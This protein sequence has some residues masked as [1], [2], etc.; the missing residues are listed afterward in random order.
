MKNTMRIMTNKM[1]GILLILGLIVLVLIIGFKDITIVEAFFLIVYFAGI[2]VLEMHLEKKMQEMEQKLTLSDT[3]VQCI[4]TL[5]DKENTDEALDNL[6]KIVGDYF[7]CERAYIFE[8]NPEKK[9]L[10]NTYEYTRMGIMREMGNRQ[11]IPLKRADSWMDAF[12]KHEI[13]VLDN[14]EKENGNKDFGKYEIFIDQH[15]NALIAAPLI[16]DKEIIGFLG[17]ENPTR[18]MKNAS[19]VSSTVYF[20]M[21]NLKKR[22]MQDMLVRLSFEDALTKMY[23]RNKFNAVLDEYEKNKPESLGIAYFDL[24]GLKVMNDKYGHKA[25]DI[26]IRNTA[27]CVNIVFGDSA[28]RI[29]GDEFVAIVAD[30]SEKEFDGMINKVADILAKDEISISVGT[31]WRGSDNDITKQMHEADEKM[32]KNKKRYYKK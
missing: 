29:G 26:L 15:I 31:S 10:N 32:Y 30:I 11:N 19:L 28:F 18:N 1:S 12:R 5:S 27:A 8:S 13:L 7:G 20:L 6:L 3:L 25:G 24:N 23:N 22:S 9:V 2:F 17:I 14:R 21:D 4:T 16:D